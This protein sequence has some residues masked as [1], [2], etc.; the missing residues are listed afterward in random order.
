MPESPQ[1]DKIPPAV[2]AWRQRVQ[3]QIFSKHFAFPLHE[4]F[5]RPIAISFFL[6]Y[7]LSDK[8]VKEAIV[9]LERDKLYWN[10]YADQ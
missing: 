2:E 10:K 1:T 9:E 5:W 8:E 4:E 6:G 7:G 3:H